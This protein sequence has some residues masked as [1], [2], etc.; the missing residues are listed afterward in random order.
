MWHVC[1]D[2][3]VHR[4]NRVVRQGVVEASPAQR[5]TAPIEMETPHRTRDSV[6][7]S[8]SG[9]EAARSVP[10]V[11]NSLACPTSHSGQSMHASAALWE[12]GYSSLP[13]PSRE[14][15]RTPRLSHE[16]AQSS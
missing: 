7:L 5:A 6:A 8:P 3:I 4:Q 1:F 13:T 16:S 10:T 14:G 9:S 11:G 15:W 2:H 12:A